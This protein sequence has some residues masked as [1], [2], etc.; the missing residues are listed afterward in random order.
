MEEDDI[1]AF[2]VVDTAAAAGWALA[3]AMEKSSPTSEPRPQFVERWTRE[4]WGKDPESTWLK[5]TDSDLGGQLVA[6]AL[7]RFQ[8]EEE[9]PQVKEMPAPAAELNADALV[10]GDA[11]KEKLP[12]VMD[13]MAK[14]WSEFKEEFIG[15]KRHASMSISACTT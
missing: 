10:S 9:K 8:L 6:A 11:P 1:P 3:Q 5:V 2:A 15:T 13:A 14:N 4:G 7:W 12:T